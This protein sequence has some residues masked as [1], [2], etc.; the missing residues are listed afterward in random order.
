MEVITVIYC[1]TGTVN[2]ANVGSTVSSTRTIWVLTPPENNKT[3]FNV[4]S[5]DPSSTNFPRKGFSLKPSRPGSERT[6]ICAL[7]VMTVL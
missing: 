2:V 6:Y 3:E 7:S 5:E 1:M 4:S